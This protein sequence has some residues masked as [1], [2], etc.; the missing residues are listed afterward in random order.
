MRYILGLFI[1]IGLLI[2]L[3]IILVSGGSGGSS[4]VPSTSKTLDS[5]ASTDARVRMT[6]LGPVVANSNYEGLRITIDKNRATFEQ[7]QN[8]DNRVVDSKT[9]DNTQLA[10]QSFLKALDKAGFTKGNAELK[11]AD[12]RGFCPL[13]STYIFELIDKDNA[14]ERFWSNSCGDPK[15]YYGNLSLTMELFRRQIP[16][17]NQLSSKINF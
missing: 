11:D 10:Y 14:I 12:Y 16:G 2:A 17:Y 1:T 6:I 7:L 8:Y 13:G 4:K 5:Y 15:T 3:I 9:F